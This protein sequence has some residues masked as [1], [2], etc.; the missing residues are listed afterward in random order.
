MNTALTFDDISPAYVSVQKLEQLIDF[1]N[2]INITTTL[3]VIPNSH[4]I[5]PLDEEYVNTLKF[6]KDSEHEIALHGYKH[7]RMLNLG[8]IALKN[9]F[10]SLLPIPW[11]SYE[12]QKDLIKRGMKCLREKLGEYPVGF[13]APSYLHNRKTLRV[14]KELGFNYDS[15]KTVF[16]PAHNCRF[17]IKTFHAPRPV[18]IED[19]TEIPITGDYTYD[20]NNYNT[21]ERAVND[22]RWVRRL[23]GVFVVNTH[24]RNLYLELDFLRILI[25]KLAPNT[26]FL[27]LKDLASMH[28][29]EHLRRDR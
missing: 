17:R 7:G 3:F 28:A 4:G 16:K 9:E 25:K 6:A 14:L 26:N 8:G 29:C 24:I 19:I 2:K 5:Y 15:S 1:L 22:F 12:K 10:G 27:R 20:L 11:P 13:R 18:T 23:N 21:L